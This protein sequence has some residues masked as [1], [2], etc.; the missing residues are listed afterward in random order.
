MLLSTVIVTFKL[1]M[2]NVLST[3]G[4]Q[5]KEFQSR[6]H[7]SVIAVTSQNLR[8]LQSFVF[9][10]HISGFSSAW[11]WLDSLIG[12]KDCRCNVFLWMLIH[13]TQSP[14]MILKAPK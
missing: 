11:F 5:S 6:L 9:L 13:Y 1:L 14:H 12:Y 4:I 10:A 3:A 7:Y 2:F 8:S